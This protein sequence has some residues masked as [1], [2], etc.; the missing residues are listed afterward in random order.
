MINRQ[1]RALVS[2]AAVAVAM[3]VLGSDARAQS[4]S[5]ASSQ[6]YTSFLLGLPAAKAGIALMQSYKS[7]ERSLIVLKNIPLPGPGIIRQIS[8]LYNQ[9]TRVFANLQKNI[10][11]LVVSRGVLVQQYQTLE[12][13]KESL[14]AKGKI[15]Q[16]QR[17]AIQQGQVVNHLNSLQGLVMAERG[18]ATPAR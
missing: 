2:F 13:K 18:L 5:T 3:M 15:T 8:S 4:A 12:S 1:R 11:A 10:N 16:A 7:L 17:V 6:S 9:E 14:L